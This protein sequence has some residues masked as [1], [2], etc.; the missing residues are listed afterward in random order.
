MDET[1][2]SI[3]S[4][5]SSYLDPCNFYKAYSKFDEFSSEFSKSVPS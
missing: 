2:Y 1:S 3:L 5:P 4:E